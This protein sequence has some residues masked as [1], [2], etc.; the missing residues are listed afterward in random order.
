[1]V[2]SG[3]RNDAL[4]A[5]AQRQALRMKDTSDQEIADLLQI[6]QALN[7]TKC[8]PPLAQSEVEQILQSALSYRRR[9]E[10]QV[11]DGLGF[12]INKVAGQLHPSPGSIELTIY[13]SD[14]VEYRLHSPDWG[15]HTTNGDGTITLTA[16]QFENSKLVALAVLE[17]TRV[18]CLD[19]YP[20]CWEKIW[21]GSAATKNTDAVIGLKRQLIDQA[22]AEGRVLDASP[23]DSRRIEML[24]WVVEKID[25][26]M[27]AAENDSLSPNG[28]P[29]KRQDGSIWFSWTTMVEDIARQ[30]QL[31]PG[32]KKKLKRSVDDI[33]GELLTKQVKFPDGS[34][35]LFSILSREQIALFKSE[36]YA[37]ATS[38]PV[39]IANPALPPR[40]LPENLFSTGSAGSPTLFDVQ[41]DASGPYDAPF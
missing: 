28:V 14:P 23:L 30:H 11:F 2:T 29:Q 34:S 27:P 37:G 7:Q 5:Y 15:R 24:T 39:E 19:P 22:V 6:V 18:V 4:F 33:V 38:P 12:V 9:A 8:V 26:A 21:H 17:Q 16:A 3:G 10:V 36:I 25:T 35:K 13:K 20:G 32:E 41:E 40:T 31:E 1:M